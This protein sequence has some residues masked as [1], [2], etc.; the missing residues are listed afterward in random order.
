MT[1]LTKPVSRITSKVIRNRAVIVTVAPC[2][3]QSEARV[4]FRLAGERTQYVALVSDLYRE[5]A[6]WH[7]Q[8]EAAAKRQARRDGIP[9]RVARKAF[10]R[11]NSI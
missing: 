9:W 7:G 2:G 5:V 10:L 4:G 3:S 1:P 8:R 11:S 6:R